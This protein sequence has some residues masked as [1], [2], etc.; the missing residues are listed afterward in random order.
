MTLPA[1]TS[2]HNQRVK[3]AIKLRDHRQRARQGR[4]FIDGSRELL[5]AMRGTVRFLEVFVCPPWCRS[6]ESRQVLDRLGQI[7][8][9]IWQVLPEVFEKMAYGHR[10]EGVLAI[11][12]TPYPALADLAV[13]DRSLIAVLE[14]LE[15]PGNVGAVLRSADGGGV[16]AAVV[17]DPQ[18]DLFNPNCIRA[19]LGTIFTNPVC[20]STTS[21][22][23]AWLR[24]RGSKIFVARLDAE[25]LY[26]DVDFRGD[27]A[28]VLGSEA[29]GLSDAW[30]AA[31]ITP[32]K[33]PMR[34][35]ADSLNVSATAAVLFYEAQRQREHA[36]RGN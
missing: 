32:I 27:T 9:D 22:T 1:I 5:Q 18:T 36:P 24:R 16:A 15:K 14:A 17:A 29:A 35:T 4:F 28:L 33:L 6:A 13:P 20:Q 23:L 25:R 30:Q 3:D 10:H 34:G 12:E 2:V 7:Q 11:A 21:E 19:S 31:D 26:T 8:A